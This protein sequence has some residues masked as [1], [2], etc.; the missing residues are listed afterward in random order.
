MPKSLSGDCLV[1]RVHFT[2]ANARYE[3]LYEPVRIERIPFS[4]PVPAFAITA[5]IEQRL[6]DDCRF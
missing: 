6:S 4:P 2:F 3:G 5:D 1:L